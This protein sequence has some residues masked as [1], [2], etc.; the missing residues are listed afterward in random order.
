[1]ILKYVKNEA[2][3]KGFKLVLKEGIVFSEGLVWK[4]KRKML[5]QI[6]TFDMVKENIGNI[7]RTC[8]EA[9][10][11]FDKKFKCEDQ[12]VR[13][14][15]KLLGA[16]IF[17]KIIMTCFFGVDQIDEPVEGKDF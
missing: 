13:Y 8:D 1:M 9:F 7:C 11:L 17:N 10:E 15:I 12:T 5:A 3:S 14:N 2:F 6:F 4:K 16:K